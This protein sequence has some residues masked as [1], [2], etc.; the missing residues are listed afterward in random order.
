[1][2]I[3]RDDASI[4]AWLKKFGANVRRKRV[5]LL[6]QEKLAE[7]AELSTRSIQKIEAG[8]MNIRLTTAARIQNALGCK[9]E[10]LMP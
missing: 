10:D 8:S 1:M 5:D 6:T 2:L 9:W 4:V 7:L 3:P